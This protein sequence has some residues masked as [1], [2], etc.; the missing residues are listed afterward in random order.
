MR[1]LTACCWMLVKLTGLVQIHRLCVLWPSTFLSV[2][3]VRKRL[4]RGAKVVLRACF[5]RHAARIACGSWY[6]HSVP[7]MKQCTVLQC[8]APLTC[9]SMRQKHQVGK[10]VEDA[11][12]MG[13]M[14]ADTT[15]LYGSHPKTA[16]ELAAVLMAGTPSGA[17]DDDDVAMSSCSSIDFV[18]LTDLTAFLVRGTAQADGELAFR[19]RFCPYLIG[20]PLCPLLNGSRDCRWFGCVLSGVFV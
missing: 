16:S 11:I 10:A 7:H 13:L 15:V 9:M 17:A 6:V 18:S 5:S 20:S 2:S 1:V 12:A 14:H 19:Q 3:R 8:T 4:K